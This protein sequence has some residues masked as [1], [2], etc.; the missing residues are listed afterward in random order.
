MK[1]YLKLVLIAVL[2]FA[3]DRVACAPQ[4]EALAVAED[5]LYDS[6]HCIKAMIERA[7]ALDRFYGT[8]ANRPSTGDLW[9]LA[10]VEHLRTCRC[11]H[12]A[13]KFYR[14]NRRPMDFV[15]ATPRVGEPS[16]PP[17]PPMPPIHTNSLGG[18]RVPSASVASLLVPP[19]ID[20]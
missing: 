3:W 13:D 20:E 10:Q 9:E 4:R 8:A 15:V 16:M 14:R 1:C 11:S 18:L 7:Q 17:M 12:L 2:A 5:A 6:P 19:V